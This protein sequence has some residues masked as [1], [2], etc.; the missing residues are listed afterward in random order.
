MSSPSIGIELQPKA[1]SY[2]QEVLAKIDINIGPVGA[3]YRG[4]IDEVRSVARGSKN[5]SAIYIEGL[6]GSG[7]TLV[8]RKLV[9]DIISGPLKDQFKNIMPIYFFLGG[10]DFK[11]LQGLKNYI[12]ELKTYVSSER[13]VP[14]KPYI[15]GERADW[16]SRFP[17]LEKCL[18]IV[19]KVEERYKKEEEKETLGFFEVLGEMNKQEIDGESCRPLLIFD[20]F[21]RVLYTGD[22][23]KTD[24]GKTAF[25]TFAQRYL[26]LTRGHLYSGGFIIAT[27]KPIKDLLDN[28]I[29]ERRPHISFIFERLGLRMD[30]P[31]DFHMIRPH[32][33]YDYWDRL[34]WLYQHLDDLANKYGFLLHLDLLHLISD[35]LPI[36]R[37]IIQIDRKVRINLGRTPNV[38]SPKEFYNVIRPRIEEFIEVLK[39]EKIGS[40]FIIAPRTLWHERF[41]KLLENGYFV[42]RSSE[43]EK[44]AEALNITVQDHDK[45]KQRVSQ[46]L[47]QLSALG[48]YERLGAGEYRLNPY[49]LAYALEIESLPD[50]SR[51]DLGELIMKIKN[52]I[53]KTRE[54]REKSE[55]EKE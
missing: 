51:A 28:A 26:E 5:F 14:I 1:E 17:L 13:K 2:S 55:S 15:L 44:V 31:E 50:G 24:V 43:Y 16:K 54:E 41:V 8:L 32:I 7:K 22:G 18:E 37:T 35:I 46:I 29:K 45:S 12:E 52:A 39:K 11:L 27:T 10:M 49:I 47:R 4:V 9:Y 40:R 3:V 30:R 19:S 21:E 33:V 25:V 6:Y 36:P 34:A 48:L 23:L 53:I 42:I 20:E 38:V